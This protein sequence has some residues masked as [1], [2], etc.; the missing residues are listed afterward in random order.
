VRAFP[1]TLPREVFS[2]AVATVLF[3]SCRDTPSRAAT[4][5]ASATP[6]TGLRLICFLLL[7]ASA[8]A[9]VLATPIVR[10]S[11]AGNF[12]AGDT[13]IVAA[14]LAA[15]ALGLTFHGTMLMLNRGFFSLG[16]RGSRAGSRSGIS[17]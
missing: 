1:S 10:L 11:P 4:G 9:A 5:T 6:G 8:A 2:V 17:A 7:P 3:R 12:T 13:P 14:C 16:S 15:F